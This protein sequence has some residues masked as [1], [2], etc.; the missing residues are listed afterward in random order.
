MGLAIMYYSIIEIER[1]S[2]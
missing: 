2:K 1:R